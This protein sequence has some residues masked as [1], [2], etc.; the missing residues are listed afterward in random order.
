[1]HTAIT[2]HA[3]I[4]GPLV[5]MVVT[6]NVEFFCCFEMEPTDRQF[7]EMENIMSMAKWLAWT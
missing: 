7:A 4:Q 2:L 1:M 6:S 3:H 5:I